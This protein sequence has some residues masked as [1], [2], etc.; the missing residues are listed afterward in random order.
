MASPRSFSVSIFSGPSLA[1]KITI[2]VFESKARE[3]EQ[4]NI[5]KA[6]GRDYAF[7]Y[8]ESGD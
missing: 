7:K 4:E 6:C 3:G 2:Y 1:K 5:E 8:E